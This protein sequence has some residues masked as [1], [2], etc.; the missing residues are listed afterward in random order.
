MSS[1]APPETADAFDAAILV[2][3]LLAIDFVGL[4]GVHLIARAGP[5]RDAFLAAVRARLP[6]GT[7]VRKIPASATVDR[8]LGGLALAATLRSGAPVF[9][10]GL[11]AECDG[12]VAILAMA[13]RVPPTTVAHIAAVLDSGEVVVERDGM[14]ARLASRFAVIACDEGIGPEE[15]LAASLADRLAFAVSLDMCD[16]RH[17]VAP[18]V[19][20]ARLARARAVLSDVEAEGSQLD[21]LT[22]AAHDL[23]IA[24][25][26]PPLLALRVCRALAALDGRRAVGEDDVVAAI[27][28]VLLPRATHFAE[29]APEEEAPQDAENSEPQPSEHDASK[30]GQ[31]ETPD[32]A[33]ESERLVEAARANLPPGVLDSLARRGNR[34]PSTAQRGQGA[35]MASRF[36]GRPV[37]TRAGRPGNGDR[38]SVIDTIKA[39]A[40]WQG[41]RRKDRPAAAN[42]RTL[43][44][45]PADFRIRTFKDRR[46]NVTIF[47]V[48]ASGSMA[49]SR[50][51]EAK[52]A[53]EH[54][55]TQSY[56]RRDHVALIAFRGTAAQLLLPPTRSLTRARREL[57]GLPGGGGTPLAA[58][59]DAARMLSEDLARKG[60]TPLVVVLS[61]GRANIARDGSPGR[62]A[63]REEAIQ[64]ARTLKSLAVG[65]VVIDTARRAGSEARA[66]A[67]AA[68]A[69]YLWLPAGEAHV[70]ASQVQTALGAQRV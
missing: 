11:L 27:G 28:L 42:D 23:G 61:D 34:A 58:G 69:R 31:D 13:E 66:L 22:R 68:D 12:G 30:G 62:R 1:P 18:P 51:A 39:A 36:R 57:S 19:D 46:E 63:A 20:R 55:L 59:L 41:V 10:R 5:V 52:G 35:A 3:D 44:I 9:E 40:P 29:P 70:I 50:L 7:P 47:L 38:L 60:L 6:D 54:L 15:S 67:E 65:T 64:A 56:S 4:G 2:A 53:I 37:G 45:A 24:S 32:S 21:V 14:R 48:D 16:P 26:R 43:L 33:S 25:L 17:T 49:M 8:L